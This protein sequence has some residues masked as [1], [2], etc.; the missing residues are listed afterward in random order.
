MKTY[1]CLPAYNEEP[2]IDPLFRRIVELNEKYTSADRQIIVVLY[3]DGSTDGTLD[4]VKEW[5]GKLDVIVI[6]DPVNQGLGVAV[7]SL[8]QYFVSIAGRDDVAVLMDCDDTHDPA[9]IPEMINQLRDSDVV[10]ASRY[11]KGSATKGV[12]VHRIFMSVGFLFFAKM[13]LPV[14]GVRDYS[15]GYRA[16]SS[17]LLVEVSKMTKGNFVSETGFAAMPEL[18]WN[19]ALAGARFREI[20]MQLS[21]ER[22]L[23]DSKMDVSANSLN[24]FKLFIRLRTR[25][26]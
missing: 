19:C 24:L 16:Y 9:Q 21:Y 25:R 11:R 15:C 20:P 4:R 13:V 5:V 2:S 10:I 14:K 7:K 1:L 17:P 3:D 8:L 23:S 12:P 18:L 22:K 6:S 26:T